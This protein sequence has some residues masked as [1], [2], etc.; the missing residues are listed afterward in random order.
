MSIKLAGIEFY[1]ISCVRHW[2][3]NLHQRA[4]FLNACGRHSDAE[5]L[6]VLFRKVEKEKKHWDAREFHLNWMRPYKE[7]KHP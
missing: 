7:I 5:K 4:L 3:G 2:L 6:M 1:S